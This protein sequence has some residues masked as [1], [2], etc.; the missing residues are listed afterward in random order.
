VRANHQPRSEARAIG[1][2]DALFPAR[3]AS[4]SRL[5]LVAC[6]K[7]MHPG[8]YKLAVICWAALLGVFWVTFSGSASALFMVAIGTVYAVMFFGV[9]F[10]MSRIG[11]FSSRSPLSLADFVDGRFDTID[12]PIGGGEALLQVILVPFALGI[13]GAAIGIIIHLARTAH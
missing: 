6:R 4:A 10:L 13:G 11:G 2:D 12:G 3:D 1:F 8:V 9:P 7:D 5:R